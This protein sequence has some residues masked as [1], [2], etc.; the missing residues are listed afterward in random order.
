MKVGSGIVLQLGDARESFEPWSWRGS[1]VAV[2]P[3]P[4]W[5]QNPEREREGREAR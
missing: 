4:G 3:S 1:L 5:Q 2:V